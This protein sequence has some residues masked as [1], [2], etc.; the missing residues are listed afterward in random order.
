MFRVP[1][2]QECFN[3]WFSLP[4][5]MLGA[6]NN[7]QE[8]PQRIVVVNSFFSEKKI[9][10]AV[11]K[12]IRTKHP[13]SIPGFGRLLRVKILLWPK[14][15]LISAGLNFR[16]TLTHSELKRLYVHWMHV[17]HISLVQFHTRFFFFSFCS[18]VLLL[19]NNC[20]ARACCRSHR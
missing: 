3:E 20:L 19:W 2:C 8:D 9:N 1:L 7:P 13:C 4:V 5:D 10:L 15:G 14:L 12:G 17:C 6:L 11:R 16:S 18:F